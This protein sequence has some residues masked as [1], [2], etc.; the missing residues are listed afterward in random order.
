MAI[1][2]LANGPITMTVASITEV[3]GQYGAQ[4]EFNDGETS[5]FINPDTAARQL[6]RLNLDAETALGT[7]LAFEQVNKA[8]KTYT[9]ITHANAG[10]QANAAPRPAAPARAAGAAP[11][12]PRAA[13]APPRAAGMTV[14]EAGDLYRQCVRAAVATIGVA[15][16]EAG[17]PVDG[18]VIQSAAATI[19]IAVKGRS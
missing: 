11:A 9:N 17:I 5:V 12:A 10:A 16:D 7:T 4:W 18:Q 6:G 19:F 2:K 8:G 14:E 3:E 1:H 15:L 13:V